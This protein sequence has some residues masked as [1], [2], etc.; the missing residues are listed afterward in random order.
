MTFKTFMPRAALAV[1]ALFPA[2]ATAEPA[3]QPLAARA[4]EDYLRQARYPAWSEALEPGAADPL[5]DGRVPTRQSRLGPEGA[6][7][8]LSVWADTIAA[9]P[10]EAVTLF[11][12][13]AHTGGRRNLVEALPA[14]GSAVTGARVTGVLRAQ[15]LGT[16]S[17]LSYRDDGIAPDSIAGDGVYSARYTLPARGPAPGQADSVLV[18]VTAVLP[19]GEERKA[20]GGFQYSNPA[21][22][23]TGR[24]T[25]V[26]RDGNLVIAAEVEA[27]AP[28]RV[29]L[30]GTLADA[31]HRPF[32]TAQ[33]ARELQPGRQWVELPFYG[34]AFHDRAVVGAVRLASVT[35]ASTGNMPNALGPVATEAHVTRAYSLTQ[36]TRAPFNRPDLVESARRL[37]VDAAAP[38]LR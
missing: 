28:G 7:P 4:A 30:S 24:Y 21:A 29:H 32:A 18:A 17:S 13:L 3:P 25:D 37:S 34:L 19:G 33:A 6:G 11:A 38:A 20:A 22:R 14:A 35:L 23:L 36:F 26:A 2:L 5:L 1:L 27:L 8:R 31:A 12:A 15:R 9:R 16:L 10:G